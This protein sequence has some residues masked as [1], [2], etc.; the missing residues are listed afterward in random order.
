MDARGHRALVCMLVV[1]GCLIA[2]GPGAVAGADAGTG[3]TGQPTADTGQDAESAAANLSDADEIH[4][5][6]DVYENRS[7]MVTVDYR[8][9][10][11]R[12]NESDVDWAELEGD[13]EANPDAYIAIENEKWQKTV[14]RGANETGREMELSNFAV[15][16]DESQTP[17]Q[18]GHVRFQFEW[19]SFA[20]S[21]PKYLEAGDALVGFTLVDRTRLTI[22]WPETYNATRIEPEPTTREEFS[23]HWDGSET[24]FDEN[25]PRV[26]LVANS[27]QDSSDEDE[28]GWG[29]PWQTGVMIGVLASVLVAAVGVAG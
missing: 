8:Y 2:V 4:V 22:A 18:L 13:I 29:I 12:T 5:G 14:D 15:M 1:I 26:E 9:R 19:S 24:E 21:E 11:N 20:Y 7:A 23:A 16:T 3:Q 25:Q 27:A 10:L 28:L 17:V 6:I